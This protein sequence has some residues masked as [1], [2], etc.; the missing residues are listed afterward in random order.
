MEFIRLTDCCIY[1]KGAVNIGYVHRGDTGVLIDT[2][3]DKQTIKKVIRKLEEEKLPITHLIITHAH[4]DHY[5]GAAFLQ[6]KYAIHTMAPSI[7]DSILRNPII[8][9][10]YLF[11]GVIL[12]E[13]RSKFLEGPAVRIDE[14]IA[15]GKFIIEGIKLT[16]YSFPGHSINQIGILVDK[17]LYAA[18][19]YFSKEQIEKHRILFQIDIEKTLSSL[20]KAKNI[21]CI[22]ALPGHGEYE[23]NPATTIQ[24][25]IDFHNRVEQSLLEILSEMNTPVTIEAITKKMCVK[26]DVKV[27]NIAQWAMMRTTITAYVVRIIALKKAEMCV[28]NYELLVKTV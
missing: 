10:I 26:W 23:E 20:E 3:I 14:V 5:G 16:S 28:Q 25:N 12:P 4:A 13:M 9:P 18:D 21:H 19:C 6:E 8:E 7:E 17:V 11:N 24:F 1:F 27:N 15:E 22:G 2:G